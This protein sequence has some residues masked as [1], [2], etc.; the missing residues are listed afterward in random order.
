MSF[1]CFFHFSWL[2]FVMIFLDFARTH[3]SEF[4]SFCFLL[5]FFSSFPSRCLGKVFHKIYWS[6]WWRWKIVIFFLFNFLF[7]CPRFNFNFWWGNRI[8]FV[9]NIIVI[10]DKCL[11]YGFTLPF[12]WT[13]YISILGEFNYC[14]WSAIRKLLFSLMYLHNGRFILFWSIFFKWK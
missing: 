1:R 14:L 9:I 11:F 13:F 6:C 7:R 3:F 2:L 5:V 10:L 4:I 12:C 8:M